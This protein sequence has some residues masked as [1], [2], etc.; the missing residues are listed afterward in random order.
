MMK[1][2]SRFIIRS[3]EERRGAK[4]TGQDLS[5]E[6]GYPVLPAQERQGSTREGAVVRSTAW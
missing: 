3:S 4:C 1:Q 6:T 5:N 2:K